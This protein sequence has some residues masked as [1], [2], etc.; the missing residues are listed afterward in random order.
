MSYAKLY[1]KNKRWG[2]RMIKVESMYKKA[3]V[4]ICEIINYLDYEAYKNIPAKLIERMEEEKDKEYTFELEPGVELEKQNLLPETRAILLVIFKNYLATEEQK[5]KLNGM[6]KESRIKEEQRKKENRN[7]VYGFSQEVSEE[8]R[9]QQDEREK[10]PA[11]SVALVK[12][13]TFFSRIYNFIKSR[14]KK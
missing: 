5:I 12:R 14:L 11:E 6:L 1:I 2:L 4:E 10:Q 3:Y 8:K 7:Q 9:K 13:E